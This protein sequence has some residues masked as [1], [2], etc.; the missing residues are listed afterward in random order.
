[1]ASKIFNDNVHGHID[2]HPLCIKVID[3]PQFQRLRDISQLGGTYYVFTGASCNRFEHS[4]GVSHL[5]KKFIERLREGQPELDITDE[6]VVCVELAG[7]C[8]DLGHGPFSHLFE[9]K[10]LKVVSDNSSKFSHE[11][12]SIGIFKLLIEENDLMKEFERYDLTI[13]DIHFIQ[14][15]ILGDKEDAPIGFQWKGRGNKTF[16]YDIVANKRNGIDVDKFDYFA[17]DCQA[18]GLKFT[19]DYDRIMRFARVFKVKR[20]AS[21]YEYDNDSDNKVLI[22]TPIKNK[23]RKL[24]DQFNNDNSTSPTA[25]TSATTRHILHEEIKVEVEFQDNIVLDAS[26]SSISSSEELVVHSITPRQ[27][28]IGSSGE[29]SLSQSIAKSMDIEHHND[30]NQDLNQNQRG[31]LSSLEICFKHSEA[32]NLFELFHTRYTLHKRAYQHRVSNAV[33]LMIGQILVLADPFITVPGKDRQLKKMSE[34][35]Q[36][37]HAYWRLGEHILR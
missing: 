37:M 31:T 14:E 18:L 16:L 33:E 24:L 35:P 5:A 20:H 19:F 29:L 4:I 21:E 2:V 22:T 34:C 26:S 28:S 12:A 7:L 6:D 25:S 17:R 10:F 1:M 32:W 13:D 27:R 30:Q 8:H 36:D 15:L 11:H 9:N 3:T 23:K